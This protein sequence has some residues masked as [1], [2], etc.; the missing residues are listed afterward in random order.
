MNRRKVLSVLVIILAFA[1]I[2]GATMAWFTAEASVT[3]NYF[4][5]GTV[6]IRAT[7]EFDEESAG[8]WNPG[9]CID[10]EIDV[11]YEG[12]KKAIIR[13]Q[14]AEQWEDGA[15]VYDRSISNVIWKFEDFIWD[16]DNRPQGWH[17]YNKWWYY[18]GDTTDPDYTYTLG[19]NTVVGF[20]GGATPQDPIVISILDQVCLDGNL[21]GNAYQGKSYTINVKFQ[22]IQASNAD[23]W[24]DMDSIDFVTGLTVQQ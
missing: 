14:I 10:K 6:A 16:S 21:T 18:L 3:E 24:Q 8:N 15:I 23:Q 1:A 4:Q 19:D 7:D 5:A 22:A 11:I 2:G 20:V 9:Q 12:T 17:Y 13:M